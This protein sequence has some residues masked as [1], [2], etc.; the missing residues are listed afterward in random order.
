MFEV[1][2]LELVLIFVIALIVLGPAR[3]PGLVS[4]VGRWIGKAR[5][6]AQQ[7][8]EQ[9]ES[10]VNLEELNKM[11]SSPAK[12]ST[13]TY[14][15]PP[16]EFSGEPHFNPGVNPSEVPVA[17]TDATT[18]ETHTA[19]PDVT[20]STVESAPTTVAASAHTHEGPD[21]FAADPFAADHRASDPYA[22]VAGNASVSESVTTSDA[23]TVSESTSSTA[24]PE[25]PV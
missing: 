14:P 16:P 10:E 13:P 11:G 19:M 20:G 21:P 2:F 17:S 1:G 12:K 7:F 25:R 5:R 3:L 8:R 4:K 18:G 9:L 15:P 24:S 22:G 23:T 6:M